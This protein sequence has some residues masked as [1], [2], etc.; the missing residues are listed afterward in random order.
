VKISKSAAAVVGFGLLTIV[1]LVFFASRPQ[2]P[3]S[4]ALSTGSTTPPPAE[5]TASNALATP[6]TTP[7]PA[8]ARPSGQPS[9]DSTSTT[10]SLPKLEATAVLSRVVGV[11]SRLENV[12][13]S[14]SGDISD[15]AAIWADPDN[16]QQSVVIAN[17]KDE[18][19]GGIGVFGMNGKLLQYEEEGEIGNVDLRP[20]FPSKKGSIVLVGANNRSTNTL[21]LW[22]LSTQA[23]RL[24]SVHARNIKTTESNYGFCLYHSKTNGK[25]Y[26]FVTPDDEGSI[27]Q[28]ELLPQASGLVDAKLVRR[29]PISGTA[30]GCVADDDHG[31]LYVGQEEAAIWKYEAEPSRPADR[32]SVDRVGRGRLEADIEGLSIAYGADGSGYLIASSQGDSTIAIYGRGGGNPFIKRVRISGGDSTDAVTG[33]D[34][35]D[36]T[37]HN[38]GPG[39]MKGLLVV[40]DESNTDGRTSNLKYVSLSAVLEAS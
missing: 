5:A 3:V 30:E 6:S 8:K 40:H 36:V 31:K 29:L 22:T 39:F 25:F 35:L 14:G 26:A 4:G 17:N 24:S 21:E 15:D 32:V 12:G 37:T 19:A 33:T 28:F 34:G 20:G 13:F 7:T 11:R 23:R 27:Q 2:N 9:T 38:A 1:L 16:P 10:P 18:D